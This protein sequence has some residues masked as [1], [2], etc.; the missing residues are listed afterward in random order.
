MFPSALL[1]V[2]EVSS[3]ATEEARLTRAFAG[4]SIDRDYDAWASKEWPGARLVLPRSW[5]EEGLRLTFSCRRRDAFPDRPG[6]NDPK[7]NWT[8]AQRADDLIRGLLSRW[9]LSG[10]LDG[11]HE[12]LSDL[13]DR[14]A[15]SR[16]HRP[17]QDL[18]GFRSLAR[19][20]L[21]DIVTSS[22]EIQQFASAK[23][24][25]RY[26]VLEMEYVR[27]DG[28]ER[29]DLVSALSSSQRN[30]AKQVRRE[31]ELLQSILA[32]IVEAT[33]TIASIRIQ[34]L[35]I[36]LAVVSIAIAAFALVVSIGATP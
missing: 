8:I 3:P 21:F 28:A 32:V 26:D 27:S 5:G 30:R 33:Q 36:L 17:V 23:W 31:A 15:A 25:Y 7:S 10:M 14:L 34:R 35:A 24:R 13:R 2:T 20:K 6:Y 18:K 29:T 9:A 12:Q 4:L 19:T 16:A 22:H 1:L 11:Y